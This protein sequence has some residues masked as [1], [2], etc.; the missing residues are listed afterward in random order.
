MIIS[1]ESLVVATDARAPRSRLRRCD[2]LVDRC[3]DDAELVVIPAELR[4]ETADEL[5]QPISQRGASLR[6]GSQRYA[7]DLRRSLARGSAYPA[8][9][10]F[11]QRRY[12][13]VF[14]ALLAGSQRSVV[15]AG[16]IEPPNPMA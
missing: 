16:G 1:S 3:E 15:E 5:S 7:L 2:Q 12:P 4:D 10:R 14:F 6:A 8:M 13:F 9:L 11:A